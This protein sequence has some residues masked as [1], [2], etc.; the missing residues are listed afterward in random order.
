M[1]TQSPHPSEQ[2]E[3][4]NRDQASQGQVSPVHSS[5]GGHKGH[6]LMMVACCIPMLVIA[7]VLVWTGI[8]SAGLIVAALLCTA[9]MMAMMYLMPGSHD[10]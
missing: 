10:G 7:G 5:A 9:L 2:P 8:A 6:G 3:A 4:R 1:S